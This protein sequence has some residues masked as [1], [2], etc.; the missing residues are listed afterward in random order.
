MWDPPCKPTCFQ[1]QFDLVVGS[2]R[3]WVRQ[4]LGGLLPIAPSAFGSSAGQGR[5]TAESGCRSELA[6][7]E[8]HRIGMPEQAGQSSGMQ[9]DCSL[10]GADSAVGYGC[11]KTR[12]G[13]TGVDGIEYE[14]FGAGCDSQRSTDGVAQVSVADTDL[15]QAQPQR[16]ARAGGFAAGSKSVHDAL[17]PVMG[18]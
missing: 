18:I 4:R 17:H 16:P 2:P 15:V 14:T 11:G 1:L 13:A 3:P 8:G 9:K 10:A 7:R 12:H 5:F 6:S